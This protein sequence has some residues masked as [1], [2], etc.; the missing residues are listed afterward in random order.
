MKKF[1]VYIMILFFSLQVAYAETE[2]TNDT[3]VGADLITEMNLIT[4]SKSTEVGPLTFLKGTDRN[5]Y[6]KFQINATGT[7]T[8]YMTSDVTS[9]IYI[10]TAGCGSQVLKLNNAKSG[11]SVQVNVTS[12]NTII[13]YIYGSN[14]TYDYGFD[15]KFEV[16]GP[17][18]AVD[19][20]VQTAENT[21]V[22]IDVTS[23]DTDDSSIDKTTVIITSPPAHGSTS[24]DSLT[25]VVTY[26]PTT[27]YSGVDYFDYTVK[28]NLGNISNVANVTIVIKVAAVSVENC[29][30][31]VNVGYRDFCLRKQIMLPGDMLTTGN[32][33]LVAPNSDDED[34]ENPSA[35]CTTYYNGAYINDAT[36]G[37]NSYKLCK[38]HIAGSGTPSATMAE[39]KFPDSNNSEIEWA[40][41][42]WQAIIE[43]NATLVG[44]QIRIKN[45]TDAYQ[46]ISY[47]KLDYAA[48]GYSST[49]SYSAFKNVTTLLQS[50]NW[51]DGN[52]TVADI[53]VYEGKL[54][55]LGSYGAW[56]LVIIYKNH[57]EAIKSFS[58][59]DGWKKI[60]KDDTDTVVNEGNVPVAIAGFYTPK[61]GTINANVS[62][63]TAEGDKHIANDIL[64]VIKQSDNSEVTLPLLSNNS[65]NSSIDGVPSRTPNPVNNNGIDIHTYKLGNNTGGADV[66]SPEQQDITFHF[67]STQDTYWPS[68]LAFATEVYVPQFCYDYAYK[69]NGVYITEDNN[70]TL[71]APRITG[72]V[73]NGND[74]NV[75]IYIRNNE[76]SD[77]LAKNLKL[78]ILDINTTQVSYKPNT[79][80]IINPNEVIPL[81]VPDSDL[82]TSS[83]YIKNIAYQ[84]VAGTEHIYTYFS[85]N[86]SLPASLN[87]EMNISLNAT[88]TYDL[89]LPL[90]AGGEITIPSTSTLGGTNLP[91][92]STGNFQYIDQTNWSIFNVV[93]TDIYALGEKYNI[94][95][96]VV[97][98]PGRFSVVAYD[99]NDTSY[100]T[101]DI[102][103]S[104]L[105][106]IDMIDA[107]AFHDIVATCAETAAG[108]SPMLWMYFD[109]SSTID[110]NQEIV[111]AIADDRLSISSVNDY[112]P[113][114]VKSAAFRV[115]YLTLGDGS[116]D[117]VKTE[118]VSGTNNVKLINFT[119]LVQDIGTCKQPVKKFPDS[120]LTTINVPV[121]C[122]NAGNAGLTPFE[123]QRCLECLFG[124]NTN[125]ICSRDNFSIRPESFNVKLNDTNQ[126]NLVTT[127]ISDDRTGVSVPN[128]A[129]TALSA[130]YKYNYEINATT[131]TGNGAA[132]GYSR[133][134]SEANAKDFNISLIWSPS[135]ASV[136]PNCN[137]INN[138]VQVFNMING[139]VDANG[140]HSNVGEYLLNVIDKEWTSVDWD[141]AYMQ[142]HTDTTHFIG[143]LNGN[144]CIENN[145]DVLAANTPATLSGGNLANINGC[146]TDTNNHNNVN[147]GIKYRDYNLRFH[148]YD[149]NVSTIAFQKGNILS[150]TNINP[151]NAFVYMN[152]LSKDAN[153]SVRYTGRIRAV[154]ADNI[155]L[156][157]FVNGCY[158]QTLNLDIN[159]S[160]LPITAAS[161]VYSYRLR[162]TNSTGTIIGDRNGTNGGFNSM[163]GRISLPNTTGTIASVNVIDGTPN[164]KSGFFKNMNGEA[165]IELNLNFN[166][167]VNVAINPIV[168]TYDDFNVTCTTLANCQSQADMSVNHNPDGVVDSNQSILHIYGRVHTPR[169]RIADTNPATL[170][171][172]GTVP[173]YYEFYCNPALAPTC[174]IAD[175]NI[176]NAG[177]SGIVPI[178]PN[179]LLST[180][181]ILWYSQVEHNTSVDGNTTTTRTKNGVNDA[182]FNTMNIIP[183]ERSATYTYKG[184]KGYP[185]KATIELNTQDWLIYHRFNPAAINND[186][187]LEFYSIGGWSGVDK[188]SANVDSN[189]STNT[190]RRISW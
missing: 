175:Y 112:Y 132:P 18:V 110:L 76:D 67:K 124:Y 101:A 19:D 1:L 92:C 24:I 7:L 161:P 108:I 164:G 72:F 133:Y 99:Q 117:L 30:T 104:T 85:L 74:I 162:E 11:D 139:V 114:A 90:S 71:R 147:T 143:G 15:L 163:V 113:N 82:T 167:Q 59:F 75:T 111:N 154:G 122:A 54:D 3:C 107:G 13:V 16:A 46:T 155:S 43:D 50:N 136:N 64:T 126:S 172:N 135:N 170:D 121:A 91:L 151:T 88:F 51:K 146:N 165:Q 57:T 63:F 138:S 35:D 171:A 190:N 22:A 10:G 25:G 179:A 29:T 187:E 166:R 2:P 130:G 55:S 58:V 123:M 62:V 78:N 73:T 156:S 120:D 53:P 81:F 31:G 80:A 65:F 142:H 48:S 127:R 158:A 106:G 56:S 188:G 23:N 189:A 184:N 149:F 125:H 115:S 131:Y 145:A 41:L 183:G 177:I 5:D 8:L 119:E 39:I 12:G 38:Y 33:V 141:P 102:N 93:D 157:N 69:Q 109:G 34:S 77:V 103:S 40:G 118:P 153:M 98:R 6:F 21:A 95:T 70:D 137:D 86:P 150:N 159:T 134:F 68:M 52:Y 105:V 129:A 181:N 182:Q 17:P 44:M 96:Q 20:N 100:T 26:T 97:R 4:A 37:N 14:D 61:S 49:N 160:L 45:G 174:N 180:D 28:D 186:F 176:V 66:L 36:N 60:Q 89:I 87:N 178:S 32:T 42:Y 140:S 148:P 173:I 168:L 84:D 169:T 47:D 152:D 94:P 27:G 9:D 185:Y 79:V 128:T 144:D 83:S 116:G